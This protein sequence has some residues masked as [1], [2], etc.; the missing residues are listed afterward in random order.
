MLQFLP[1]L[2]PTATYSA[3]EEDG[4]RALRLLVHAEIEAY[5]EAMCDRLVND[6]EREAIRPRQPKPAVGTWAIATV[7]SCRLA[8]GEN[9]GVK[10]AN[11]KKMFGPLG[12]QDADFD[13]VSNVFLDRMTSFGTRRGVVAHRSAIRAAY[14]IVRQGEEKSINEILGYLE[15]FDKKLIQHRLQGFI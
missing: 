14:S 11:I 7:R 4:M 8:I 1:P 13:A 3:E 12:I 2:S 15:S 5:L 10:E 9:H 6:L